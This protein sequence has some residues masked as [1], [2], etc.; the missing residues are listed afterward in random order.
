MDA[1]VESMHATR[2]AVS[3]GDAVWP[4]IGLGP[5]YLGESLNAHSNVCA[6]LCS[7]QS[8]GTGF[9]VSTCGWSGVMRQR[10]FAVEPEHP[11]IDGL[12]V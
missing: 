5:R 10:Q 9:S 4:L 3:N 12:L 8:F 2:V 11:A 1:Y 7:M 6:A